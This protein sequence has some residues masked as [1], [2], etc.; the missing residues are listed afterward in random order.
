MNNNKKPRERERELGTFTYQK[1]ADIKLRQL[2]TT[3]QLHYKAC[4]TMENAD[5]DIKEIQS[6]LETIQ[7]SAGS[8]FHI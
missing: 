4:E 3:G 6:N 1:L 8:S 7:T 5:R 2:Q